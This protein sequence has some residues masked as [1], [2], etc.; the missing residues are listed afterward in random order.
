MVLLDSDRVTKQSGHVRKCRAISRTID[1]SSGAN[2]CKKSGSVLDCWA[3]MK[4]RDQIWISQESDHDKV[5]EMASE[6]N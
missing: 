1:S 6:I 4:R 2:E 3:E 5:L